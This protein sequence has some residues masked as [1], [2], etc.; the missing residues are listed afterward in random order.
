MNPAT[1]QEARDIAT[2][3]RGVAGVWQVVCPPYTFL[4]EVAEVVRGRAGVSVGAQDVFWEQTTGAYTGE[5]SLE[6]LKGFGVTHVIVGH[7]ERRTVLGERDDVVN[8]KFWA[9]SAARLTPILCVGESASVRERGIEAAKEFVRA[10]LA[11]VFS[12]RG[13]DAFPNSCVVAYEPIWAIG[14]GTPDTPESAGE[15]MVFIR[16]LLTAEYGVPYASLACL[17]GGSVN[18]ANAASFANQAGVSGALVGGA[19]LKEDFGDVVKVFG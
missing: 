4:P 12:T 17:Y 6:M 3:V 15:M 11:S 7:S 16:N 18:V 8:K 10:Q 14:T 9:T 5:I 19:S 2:R 1:V 13:G